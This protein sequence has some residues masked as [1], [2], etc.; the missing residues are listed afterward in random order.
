MKIELR[1]RQQLA[2]LAFPRYC[3]SLATDYRNPLKLIEAIF[4]GLERAS[5]GTLAPFQRLSWELVAEEFYLLGCN[6]V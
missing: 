3:A 5:Q 2:H 6:A 1:L 4:K